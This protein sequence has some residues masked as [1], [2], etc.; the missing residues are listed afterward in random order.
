MGNIMQKKISIV[1][2]ISLLFVIV[3]AIWQ[4]SYIQNKVKE[5]HAIET[6]FVESVNKKE[7]VKKEQ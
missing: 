4:V 5:E 2:I 7:N 1:C 3:Q 6:F